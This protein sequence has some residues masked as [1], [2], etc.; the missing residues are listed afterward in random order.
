MADAE[1]SQSGSR[2]KQEI[3]EEHAAYLRSMTTSRSMRKLQS[4]I[5]G[6]GGTTMVNYR[7][8]KEREAARQARLG[9]AEEDAAKQKI[10]MEEQERRSAEI[11]E[12]E[13]RRAKKREKAKKKKS[14]KR[15]RS[16]SGSDSGSSTS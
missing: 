6:A 13:M 16:S 12:E 15:S 9:R 11:R 10:S 3:L 7:L 4:T 8:E 2:S 5:A 1:D 14:R